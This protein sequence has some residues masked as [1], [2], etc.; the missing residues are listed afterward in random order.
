M[1]QFHHNIF[2]I[3]IYVI[4]WYILQ[5]QKIY[6]ADSMLFFQPNGIDIFLISP[7]KHMLWLLSKVFLMTTH[8]I[9]FSMEK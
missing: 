3:I 5:Q 6:K 8:N 7:Q 9:C 4:I 1:Y 2:Y